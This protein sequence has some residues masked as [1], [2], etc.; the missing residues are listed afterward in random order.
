MKENFE[1]DPDTGLPWKKNVSIEEKKGL[2]EKI[3]SDE[4]KYPINEAIIEN[5]ITISNKNMA[6]TEELAIKKARQQLA[7]LPNGIEYTTLIDR[8]VALENE[9]IQIGIEITKLEN[10][11]SL[12][13]NNAENLALPNM[14]NE[15]IGQLNQRLTI[16][17][18]RKE[19]K[20]EEAEN[21][22]DEINAQSKF[23]EERAVYQRINP[24]DLEAN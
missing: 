24:T 13:S 8:K 21:I 4:D 23:Q 5:G 7:Q 11:I 14:H 17:E 16:L 12:L 22:S 9:V 1:F 6:S 10:E 18:K 15:K 19:E 20:S 3:F 2:E